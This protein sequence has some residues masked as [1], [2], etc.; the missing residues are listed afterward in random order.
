M[1][2]KFSFQPEKID[3]LIPQILF[4]TSRVD[5]ETIMDKIIEN[6]PSTNDEFYIIHEPETKSFSL[7]RQD[8]K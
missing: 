3:T 1:E 5:E 2:G 8:G 4:D 7:R 6:L